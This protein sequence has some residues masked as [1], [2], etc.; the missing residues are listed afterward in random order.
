MKESRIPKGQMF[1]HFPAPIESID[2][3]PKPKVLVKVCDCIGTPDYAISKFVDNDVV[4]G[5]ALNQITDSRQIRGRD[6]WNLSDFY[7]DEQVRLGNFVPIE[8]LREVWDV[9]QARGYEMP[10]SRWAV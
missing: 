9:C 2:D 5:V 1:I 4:L 10:E 8:D 7:Y 3:N 6:E